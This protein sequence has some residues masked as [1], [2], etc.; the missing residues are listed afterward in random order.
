VARLLFHLRRFFG[1]TYGLWAALVFALLL[2]RRFFAD[3][4][5][6]GASLPTIVAVAALSGLLVGK[7]LR[8][9]KPTA[10]EGWNQVLA[11][12]ELGLLLLVSLYAVLQLTGGARSPLHPLV[13]AL[14]AFL[15][16]FHRLPVGAGLV[17]AALALE[18]LLFFASPQGSDDRALAAAHGA[19]IGFFA[20][21]NLVFL[22]VEVFRQR[23][24]HEA[25]M[26]EAIRR[27]REEARDFR[28]ISSSLSAESRTR[29]RAE[30]E[31]KLNQ[32]AVE[33]IHQGLYFLLETL[34]K[35]LGLQTCIVLWLDDAGER[36]KIRELVS[37]STMVAE[38][39]S[40]RPDQGAL[41]AIL[42]D[43]VLLNLRA[44]KRGHLP[45]YLG[46]EEV[47]AFLGVPI[48]DSGNLRGVLCADRRGDQAFS[49]TDEKLLLDAT[50]QILRVINAERIFT[51]V[52]KSKWEHE[53]FY[54]ASA[55]LNRAL[56]LDQVLGVA[57]EAAREITDFDVAAL[58]LFDPETGRHTVCKV[59]GQVRGLEEGLSFASNAGLVAMVVK[60]KHYLPAGGEYRDKE[61]PVYTKRV[62]LKGMESL[63]VLPLI[64]ADNAIG[65]F[66]LA[67]RRRRAFA[68]DTREMLGVIANQVA[69]SIENATM[70]R[71][72]EQRATTDG[73]TGLTNHRAF[74][75]RAAQFLERAQ[76]LGKRLSIILT[77][78]DKFKNVNDTYGHP[79]GDQVIKRVAA[80]LQQNVRKIDLVARYG[81]EE[82][83]MVLEEA[84]NEGA[85]QLAERIRQDMMA[86]QFQSEK[87]QFGVTLSL[88]VATF[89]EDGTDKA[90]LIEHADQALYQA[91]HSGRN[92]VVTY[93]DLPRGGKQAVNA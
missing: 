60:N 86:Q 27:L 11:D 36:L 16:A 26:R 6:P 62:K 83:C 24:E 23:R 82:F 4:Q 35:T 78:I 30:E 75:E 70:Y 17:A 91:K 51:A 84:E 71:A 43:R 93:G 34:K 20:V 50:Q 49:E 14:V 5:I 18:A 67:Q 41:G 9:L 39:H 59:E 88:G 89:P 48:I 21:V 10:R 12:V 19:F 66:M 53:R 76:R 42:H 7:L 29:S 85:V 15:V 63:L 81:G 77:D 40:F 38:E 80:V 28:V 64:C 79:V 1:L 31:E 72:M 90:T 56:T 92:R 25:R 8:R 68:D 2:A 57:L 13:Y 87:G 73:L 47:G 37:D 52:E 69:V 61:S 44:P 3:L 65:A 55:M 33:N 74:Q 54:R 32:G 22:H 45:Y 46:P 58:S